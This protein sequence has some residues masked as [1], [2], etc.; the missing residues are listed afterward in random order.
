MGK[1]RLLES[2][3][4]GFRHPPPYCDWIPLDRRHKILGVIT[5]IVFLLTFTPMPFNL[6]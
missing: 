1:T 2:F 5:I 6:D 4:M 3:C